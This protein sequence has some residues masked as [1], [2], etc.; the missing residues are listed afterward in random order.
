M[1]Q[2]SD[3]PDTFSRSSHPL[4]IVLARKSRTNK[5]KSEQQRQKQAIQDEEGR[6]EYRALLIGSITDRGKKAS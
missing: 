2:N 4:F 1:S 3:N 5:E 6:K